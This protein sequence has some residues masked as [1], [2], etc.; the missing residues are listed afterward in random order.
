M[1]RL[2]QTACLALCSAFALFGQETRSAIFGRVSDQQN[3]T[4]PG[5]TVVVT[6]ADTNTAM[7]LSTNETGYYEANLL[8]AGHYRIS[9]ENPGFRK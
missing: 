1:K 6:N 4:I 2:Q 9:V 3:A 8:I 5:A 7:T